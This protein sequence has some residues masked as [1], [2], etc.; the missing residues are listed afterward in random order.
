MIGVGLARGRPGSDGELAV[1]LGQVRRRISV[2]A[3]RV[4]VNCL[5]D[6]LKLVGPETKRAL[7]RRR[8]RWREE[9]T[10]QNNQQVVWLN[11]TRHHSIIHRGKFNLL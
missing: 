5:L 7:E 10:M 4:N 1:I 11:R 9:Q 2:T 8:W 3:V 6:K